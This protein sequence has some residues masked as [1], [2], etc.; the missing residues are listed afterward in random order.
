MAID[1][2][3][4]PP[5]SYDDVQAGSSTANSITL[6][7][8]ADTV[9]TTINNYQ[10]LINISTY[11]NNFY[12][13]FSTIFTELADDWT[14]FYV[15]DNSVNI[16]VK[17]EKWDSANNKARLW[18]T[19]PVMTTAA[20]D[21]VLEFDNT[22]TVK[23]PLCK[24]MYIIGLI[25]A[26]SNSY[27]YSDLFIENN[28]NGSTLFDLIIDDHG[29]LII[30][31]YIYTNDGANHYGRGVWSC[32]PGKHPVLE[33]HTE[34]VNSYA[35]ISCIGTDRYI[36]NSYGDT[37]IGNSSDCTSIAQAL[38]HNEI[39]DTLGFSGYNTTD[40]REGSDAYSD[41]MVFLGFDGS[42]SPFH[43]YSIRS[44]DGINW[45]AHNINITS[46]YA[47]YEDVILINQ[48]HADIGYIMFAAA[49]TSDP[50]NIINPQIAYSA[51]GMSWAKVA[52]V[53]VPNVDDMTNQYGE[54]AMLFYKGNSSENYLILDFH[55]HNGS[56]ERQTAIFRDYGATFLRYM[57]PPVIPDFY[58]LYW[59]RRFV[60]DPATDILYGILY[61]ASIHVVQS[62]DFGLTWEY[63]SEINP[64][65]V[66]SLSVDSD[67]S[68]M[69]Y[70]GD[71]F[72]RYG[73]RTLIHN[74][75][76]CFAMT[77]SIVDNEGDPARA[78]FTLI[79]FK[80]SDIVTTVLPTDDFDYYYNP[81]EIFHNIVQ[82][83]I[84]SYII[85]S[86]YYTSFSN[87][88]MEDGSAFIGQCGG[89]DT[90]N[91]RLC[92]TSTNY[93]YA[94]SSWGDTRTA[95]FAN[96]TFIEDTTLIIEHCAPLFTYV[97]SDKYDI[98][99]P[100]HVAND[101]GN[102][103]ILVSMFEPIYS[104]ELRIFRSLDGSNWT[105]V[106]VQPSQQA[107][108][109]TNPITLM[110]NSKAS[111][112]GF[113]HAV[114]PFPD[115]S[116]DYY[117]VR[118][119][120]SDG[121][122]WTQRSKPL[123]YIG[124]ELIN[125]WGTPGPSSSQSHIYSL[126]YGDKVIAPIYRDS[127]SQ[128]FLT[129]FSNYGA[130]F[131]HHIVPPLHP[132]WPS[133]STFYGLAGHSVH[134]YNRFLVY[135]HSGTEI[136]FGIFGCDADN[137]AYQTEPSKLFSS[138]DWG[139]TWTL[140]SDL[141]PIKYYSYSMNDE[142]NGDFDQSTMCMNMLH[143]DTHLTILSNDPEVYLEEGVGT[144]SAG[145]FQFVL[146]DILDQLPGTGE[147]LT[148]LDSLSDAVSLK[149]ATDLDISGD[150][151]FVTSANDGRLTS[152][153]ISD[154]S[155]LVEISSLAISG[156][157][158]SPFGVTISGT[159]AYIADL[160]YDNFI[161]VDISDPSN[162][163]ELD[164]INSTLLDGVIDIAISGSVAYATSN[165]SNSITSINISDPSNLAILDSYASASTVDARGIKISG[166]VAYIACGTG[167]DRI[168]S[169]DI[170][171]PNIL[172]ELDSYAS[173]SLLN[174]GDLCISG[175]VAYVAS[176]GSGSI[177]SIDISDPSNLSELDSYSGALM[178]YARS[179]DIS[180]DVAYVVSSVSN[181]ITSINIS[182]PNNLSE[183]DNYTSTSLD[184]CLKI[185]LSGS[186]AYIPS[187][188]ANSITSIDIT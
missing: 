75:Y 40:E 96:C 148:E 156:I 20:K 161:S 133:D 94:E 144:G 169:I 176:K 140:I 124:G 77:S 78:S 127:D 32:I 172:A 130:T 157:L 110:P 2:V 23:N 84:G 21:I 154:P 107:N 79:Q 128:P 178:S 31:G 14:I 186:V 138:S 118:T 5:I 183:I 83:S 142:A 54:G 103:V 58:N 85:A 51:D 7:I 134:N 93:I 163:S 59:S 179:V 141:K 70:G 43:I 115:P 53:V 143:S 65:E 112:G 71:I 3:D 170:S 1:I 180:G 42:S 8:A 121:T 150:V 91:Y 111:V 61:N 171:D 29:D 187:F 49:V 174:A 81:D 56:F 89:D 82:D 175:N 41:S 155:N 168:T 26:P 160:G 25:E 86:E 146:A 152:V 52:N 125:Y 95:N 27:I 18:V 164:H 106:Y 15:K 139:I 145:I 47:D 63:I 132:D 122:V 100:T 10:V 135:D 64:L 98:Y 147:N 101:Y 45:S 136:L 97:N 16:P 120:N 173:A 117:Y 30:S 60:I 13:D 126:V 6:T 162:M 149:N 80:L 72:R 102:N 109:S 114:K 4:I 167:G 88:T 116:S 182:D 165:I 188:I 185:V 33:C 92:K 151:A 181:S 67:F 17:V 34:E 159:V 57:Q 73:I 158:Q 74:G 137:N 99:F 62:S 166:N 28:R 46:Q 184:N 11:W 119:S 39:M 108:D 48:D 12:V 22:E 68:F 131:Y 36:V 123:R 35:H 50:D 38:D 37:K 104:Y 113:L 9:S 19:I 66:F 55:R 76:L 129:V 44:T 69:D 177:T 105:S 90:Y 24:H 87:Y 153:N